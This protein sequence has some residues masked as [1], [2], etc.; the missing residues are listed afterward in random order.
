M[1]APWGVG[2]SDR[3]SNPGQSQAFAGMSLSPTKKAPPRGRGS[4]AGGAGRS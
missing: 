1:R 2:T 4:A 3:W